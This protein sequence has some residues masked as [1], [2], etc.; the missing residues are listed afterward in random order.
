MKSKCKCSLSFLDNK[1]LCHGFF[2]PSYC[3]IIIINKKERTTE[4]F[5]CADVSFYP[6]NR[7]IRPVPPSKR[8]A[9]SCERAE[10]LCQGQEWQQTHVCSPVNITITEMWVEKRIWRGPCW[11]GSPLLSTQ[12]MT[13]WYCIIYNWV[14]CQQKRI[15]NVQCICPLCSSRNDNLPSS[16]AQERA[17]T[18]K[19]TCK[20]VFFSLLACKIAV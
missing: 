15:N 2:P 1:K 11:P 12:Q 17:K 4:D 5:S 16:G 14:L 19:Q 6:Y 8:T 7:S 3:I 9:L 20:P 10:V 18:N 13:R